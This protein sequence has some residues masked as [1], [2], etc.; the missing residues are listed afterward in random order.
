VAADLATLKLQVGSDALLAQADLALERE[1]RIFSA[2]AA[3][4]ATL[5]AARHQQATK[6]LARLETHAAWAGATSAVRDRLRAGLADLDCD[7]SVELMIASAPDGLCL[8]CRTSLNELRTQVELIQTR[9]ERALREL[10]A[11][12]APPEPPVASQTLSITVDLRSP[13][14]LPRLYEGIA[15]VAKTALTKPRR[16]RITFEDLGS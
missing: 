4:Y 10:N 6:A 2:Y 5:H 12:A 16:V 15:E 1:T 7:N 11:L 8:N 14:D 13:E 9:E 3:T